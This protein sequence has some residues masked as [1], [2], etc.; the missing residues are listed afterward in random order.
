MFFRRAPK[1]EAPPPQRASPP[2]EPPPD[3]QAVLRDELGLYHLWYLELRLQQEVARASRSGVP[4][5][6]VTWRMRLLPGETPAPEILQRAAE[7]IQQRLRSYDVPARI[8]EHRFAAILFD[9][10]YQAAATVAFRIKGEL[11]LRAPTPGK[12]QAGVATFGRDGVDPD[13]LIQ[14]S[15]RR[16]EEDAGAA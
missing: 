4:F 2:E 1:E 3:P 16:L 5:S 6:L 14:A 12:W 15:L 8:D 11:Q 13:A 9:A 7:I 10:D